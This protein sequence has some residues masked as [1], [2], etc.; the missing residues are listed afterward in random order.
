MQGQSGKSKPAARA[1]RAKKIPKGRGRKITRTRERS[2][3]AVEIPL[4]RRRPRSVNF[5]PELYERIDAH[6]VVLAALRERTISFSAFMEEAA[7]VMLPSV[8]K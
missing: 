6:R 8:R 4:S 5:P 2:S 7:V 1:K 3:G